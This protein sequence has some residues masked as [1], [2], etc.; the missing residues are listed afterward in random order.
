MTEQLL[1]CQLITQPDQLSDLKADWHQLWQQSATAHA[2]QN[3]EWVQQWCQHYQA[4]IQQLYI[5]AVWHQQQLVGLLPTYLRPLGNR[6]LSWLGL[7]QQQ[8]CF[9]GTGEPEHS[10]VAAEYMDLLYEPSFEEQVLQQLSKQLS[11]DAAIKAIY[12]RDIRPNAHVSQLLNKLAVSFPVQSQQ[13]SGWTFAIPLQTE[14]MGYSRNCQKKRQR[15]LNKLQTLPHRL[16]IAQDSQQAELLFQQLQHLHQQRWQQQGKAG[17]F[18]SEVFSQFHQSMLNQLLKSGQL[19]LA[20]LEVNG[21]IIAVSYGFI[22][23][24]SYLYY[25]GGIDQQFSPN[26]SPGLLLHFML[27]DH[28]KS[29]GLS[30]YDLMKSPNQQDYKASLAEPTGAVIH[31]WAFRNR[32]QQF[33]AKLLQRLTH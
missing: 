20:A 13:P 16:I 27:A 9:I 25:Q 21:Q 18:A 17:V 24:Q 23:K 22:S 2:F 7:C 32:W 10:E 6:P 33:K 8:L 5:V 15:L 28:A 3:A 29:L 19:L 31:Q 11:K 1:R 4:H 26:L 14:D 12:F 30:Q